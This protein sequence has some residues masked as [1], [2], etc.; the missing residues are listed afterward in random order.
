MNLLEDKIHG[1]DIDIGG[2]PGYDFGYDFGG[3]LELVN[4]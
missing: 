4:E 2:G 1:M 3:L